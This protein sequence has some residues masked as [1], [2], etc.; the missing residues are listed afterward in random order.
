ML[1]G[2]RKDRVTESERLSLKACV[3]T[4]YLNIRTLAATVGTLMVDDECPGIH[5]ALE[6]HDLDLAP[7]APLDKLLRAVE[8]LAGAADVVLP[9]PFAGRIACPGCETIA[10]PLAPEWRWQLSPRCTDC[11]GPFPAAAGSMPMVLSVLRT[12]NHDDTEGLSC[13]HVGLGPGAV[14]IVQADAGAD[15]LIRVPGTLDGLDGQLR[16]P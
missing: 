5:R 4:D 15:C 14:A 9:E 11:G 13:E 16:R 3:W 7:S 8:L 6:I 2:D 10:E 12:D 1:K